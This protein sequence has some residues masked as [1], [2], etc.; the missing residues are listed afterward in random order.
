MVLTQALAGGALNGRISVTTMC[1]AYGVDDSGAQSL[2]PMGLFINTTDLN[3]TFD[4][5]A[6]LHSN[7]QVIPPSGR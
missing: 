5:K 2:S 3:V 6:A 1:Y 7:I 4:G